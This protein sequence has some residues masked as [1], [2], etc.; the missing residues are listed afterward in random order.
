M[1]AVVSDPMLELITETSEC[2]HLKHNLQNLPISN[3][4]LGMIVG[5]SFHEHNYL[6]YHQKYSISVT[7][8]TDRKFLIWK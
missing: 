5:G 4:F 6:N 7:I 3:I 8:S 1:A 2:L